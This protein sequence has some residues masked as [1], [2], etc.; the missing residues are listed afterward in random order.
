MMKV[1]RLR[2]ATGYLERRLRSDLSLLAPSADERAVLVLVFTLLRLNERS[3]NNKRQG[4]Q[5]L[6]VSDGNWM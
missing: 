2:Q 3:Q 6:P 1:S 4:T 5:Q